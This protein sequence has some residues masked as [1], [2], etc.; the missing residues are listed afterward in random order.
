[1][2][3]DDEAVVA[4]DAGFRTLLVDLQ[5]LTLKIND[6]AHHYLGTTLSRHR[7]EKMP[8]SLETSNT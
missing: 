5:P 6:A 8:S 7:Q 3:L 2:K 4:L 1:M